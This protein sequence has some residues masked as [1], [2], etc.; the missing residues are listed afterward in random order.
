[1]NGLAPYGYDGGAKVAQC[2]DRRVTIAESLELK[3]NRLEGQLAE[4]NDAITAVKE[5]P[6]I[7]KVL[8]LISRTGSI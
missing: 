4:V 3:K 2:E 8:N 5:N 7:E 6:N 1:M